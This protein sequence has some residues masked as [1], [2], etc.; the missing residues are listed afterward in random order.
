MGSSYPGREPLFLKW[1][2]L[3]EHHPKS[4]DFYGGDLR[5]VINK[6]DYLQDLG[7]TC[8]YFTPIF[9]SPTNHR[10][11]AIDYF[12]IDPRLGTE[13]DLAELIE[14]SRERG[15]SVLLDGV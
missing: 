9:V 2:D 3:P 15:I 14:K 11:D 5:G 13:Q 7:V 12:K 8:I 6:L 1:N 4:R 10:Y